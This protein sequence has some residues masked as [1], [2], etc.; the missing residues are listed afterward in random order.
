MVTALVLVLLVPA[1]AGH[2]APSEAVVR[3][4]PLE[5]GTYLVTSG[6]TNAAVND[7]PMT[8]AG[9]RYTP[10]RGQSH[11]VDLIAIDRWGQ[12]TIGLSPVEPSRYL[13]YG[14]R[15]VLAPCDGTVRR[16]F[17][18][19]PDMPVPMMDREHMLGNHVVLRC[20]EV[21]V[22]L[23]HLASGTILVSPGEVVA[24]GET[25]GRAGNSGNSGNSAEPRL[26]LHVQRGLPPDSPISGEPS[27]FTIDG[28]FLVRGDI[29]RVP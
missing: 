3:F 22:V 13:I 17:D 6:G 11:A 20:G 14:R 2:R 9:K 21:H 7:H 28:R 26:H 25:L 8:L 15:R 16:A 1:V 29:L 5:A 12:R 4:A 19:A 23:A 27:W 10:W 18:D 24:T